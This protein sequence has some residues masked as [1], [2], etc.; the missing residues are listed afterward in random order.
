MILHGLYGK[1]ADTRHVKLGA[2][3]KLHAWK[4]VDVYDLCPLCNGHSAQ[5]LETNRVFRV[6]L[7]RIPT[8]PETPPTCS[9]PVCYVVVG[10]ATCDDVPLPLAFPAAGHFLAEQLRRELLF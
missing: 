7:D 10:R 8:A 5:A 3:P 6:R 1:M 9:D 2:L 4:L